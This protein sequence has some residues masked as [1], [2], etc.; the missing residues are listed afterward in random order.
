MRG[1]TVGVDRLKASPRNVNI[2][3]GDCAEKLVFVVGK[4]GD[5]SKDETI[6][7]DTQGPHIDLFGDFW[8]FYFEISV[9]EFGCEEGWSADRLGKFEIIVE[10]GGISF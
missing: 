2:F 4:E 5:A 9:A 8:L 3:L 1:G 10:V 7:S 6:E